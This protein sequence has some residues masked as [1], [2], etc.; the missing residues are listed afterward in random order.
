[1]ATNAHDLTAAPTWHVPLARAT[2]PATSHEGARAVRLRAS[3]QAA[4]LLRCYAAAGE[5]GMTSEEAGIAAG[6]A[7]PGCSYWR[8]V[9]YLAEHGLIEQ[10]DETR[11]SGAGCAQRV[12]RITDDGRRVNGGL[13]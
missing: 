8:R 12:L 1:M 4:K 9:S 7:I 2:D 5:R 10:T 3:S 13:S 11:T 6:L